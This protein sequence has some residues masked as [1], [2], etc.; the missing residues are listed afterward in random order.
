MIF[1]LCLMIKSNFGHPLQLFTKEQ[2][3]DDDY[4]LWVCEKLFCIVFLV[5]LGGIFAGKQAYCSKSI[6]N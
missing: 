1:A 2:N 3:R 4:S 5:C 6:T